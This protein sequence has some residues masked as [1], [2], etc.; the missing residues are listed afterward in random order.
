ME[1]QKHRTKRKYTASYSNDRI[2][3]SKKPHIKGKE[4]KQKR[5]P[6]EKMLRSSRNYIK[7]EKKKLGRYSKRA[8]EMDISSQE[9]KGRSAFIVLLLSSKC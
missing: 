7:Q 8:E 2:K 6:K 5:T 9:R 1:N 4:Q 3:M